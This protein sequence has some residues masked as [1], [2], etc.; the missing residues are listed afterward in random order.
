MVDVVFV[1]EGGGDDATE[2]SESVAEGYSRTVRENDGA[3]V[4]GCGR[5]S[6]WDVEY[7]CF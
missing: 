5:R 2:V 6:S 1:G 7:F 4:G 3:C